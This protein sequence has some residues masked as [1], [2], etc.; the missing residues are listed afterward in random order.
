M[1]PRVSV[2]IPV[3]NEGD[4]I[5]ACL[6]RIFEAVLLPCEVIVVYDTDRKWVR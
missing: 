5:V 2:V 1:T 3:Y 4:G 6:N